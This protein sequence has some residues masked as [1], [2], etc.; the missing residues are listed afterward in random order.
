MKNLI[1]FDSRDES[2]MRLNF[3]KFNQSFAGGGENVDNAES[4]GP[5]TKGT[6]D[7]AVDAVLK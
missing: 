2:I 7:N 6:L 5:H 4:N 1:L 3:I